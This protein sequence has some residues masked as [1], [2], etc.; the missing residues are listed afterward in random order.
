MPRD[1]PGLNGKLSLGQPHGFFGLTLGDTFQ[2]INNPSAFNDVYPE[3]GVA[4][5]FTHPDFDGFRGDRLIREYPDP[6]F[7]ASFDV[8]VDSDTAGFDLAGGDPDIFQGL[9]TVITEFEGIALGGNA[10]PFSQKE[11]MNRMHLQL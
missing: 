7:P 11:K 8:P 9:E 5:S 1:K 3:L 6:Q 4:F 2:F 10:A